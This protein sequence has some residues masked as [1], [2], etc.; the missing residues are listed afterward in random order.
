MKKLFLNTAAAAGLLLASIGAAQAAGE[1]FAGQPLVAEQQEQRVTHD[2]NGQADKIGFVS[3][4]V[5]EDMYSSY[6]LVS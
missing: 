3:Q 1:A 2:Q 6:M 4:E 5:N